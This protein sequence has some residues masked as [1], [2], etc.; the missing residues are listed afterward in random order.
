M[1]QDLQKAETALAIIGAILWAVLVRVTL[2]PLP[3]IAML[4]RR[5]DD[6]AERDAQRDEPTRKYRLTLNSR[7]L[8][9]SK[10]FG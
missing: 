2:I 9:S 10:A 7:S 6:S 1:G 8:R 4:L 3:R 5:V